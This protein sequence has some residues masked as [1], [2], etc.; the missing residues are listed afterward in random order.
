M[1]RAVVYVRVSSKEQAEGYS[2]DAQ[3]EA[4]LR[5]VAER[6]LELAEVFEDRGESARTAARPQFQEMLARLGED[7]SIG[8]LVVHKL[9][10]LAR[11]LE[12]HAMVRA[13]LRKHSVTLVSVT[14]NLEQ[15]ASGK[16]VEGVL[17]VLAEFYSAN[18]G[19]EVKKGMLEKV[20]QG[21]WPVRAPLGYKN[22]RIDNGGRRGQAVIVPDETQAPLIRKAFE[23]YATGE[24]PLSRIR[25][26]LI[27]TGLKSS[28]VSRS[29]L[30]N[31]LKNKVYIGKVVY[32]GVEYQGIHEP[33]VSEARFN[34]V[35]EVFRVRDV[36]GVRVRKHSHY[37]KGTVFC[38][39][40]GSRLCT[41]K[42]KGNGGI[43]D[44]FFCLGAQAK[45]TDCRER[46]IKAEEIESAI[47][48][49]YRG[50]ELPRGRKREIEAVLVAEV[51]QR[52]RE[53]AVSA[54]LW[55]NRLGELEAEREKLLAAYYAGALSLEIFKREQD[56]ISAE[57]ELTEQNLAVTTERLDAAKRRIER[58]L[59]YL[60]NLR[61]SY[62]NASPAVRRKYNHAFLD[63]VYVSDR[64]IK[65]VERKEPFERF[66][67]KGSSNDSLVGATGFEPVASRV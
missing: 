32:H 20:R 37:L 44:Y 65:R 3:R 21:G 39:T 48:D 63:G 9:D 30:L 10:R 52:E 1:K 47:E 2:L 24:W 59:R 31:L 18:L 64:R 11:N 4:A 51:A 29:H 49:L 13:R 60:A 58:A 38:G 46:Y 15:N 26:Y 27:E 16:L 6:G 40:C 7:R 53:R 36:A 14:E 41:T 57:H 28:A 12:D 42:A 66:L 22:V 17:A 25:D 62:L 34:R 61:E 33:L 5:L 54:K 8:Y 43:Y 19:Q 45:R 56:R 23:L 35:Q 55:T 67:S 50:V